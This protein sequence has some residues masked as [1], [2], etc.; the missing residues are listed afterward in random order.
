MRSTST[1]LRIGLAMKS[2]MPASRHALTS[3]ANALAVSAMIGMRGP[4]AAERADRARRLEPVHLGHAHVHEHDVEGCPA[5]ACSSA[6]RPFGRDGDVDVEALH[7]LGEHELIGGVVLREQD[8][9]AGAPRRDR[10]VAKSTSLDGGGA[11]PSSAA[12]SVVGSVTRNVKMEPAPGVDST[13]IVAAHLLDDALADRKAE[14]GAA[15]APADRERRP[16]RTR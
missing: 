5:C 2:F 13:S 14:A 7:Q 6:S 1:F 4:G 11:T 9:A 8:R 15:E 3:S 16:G 12:A 10:T